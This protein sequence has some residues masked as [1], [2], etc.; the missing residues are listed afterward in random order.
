M[1]AGN[2]DSGGGGGKCRGIGGEV[3]GDGAGDGGSGGD[4]G[5]SRGGWW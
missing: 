2:G 3:V 1:G 5:K 4:G